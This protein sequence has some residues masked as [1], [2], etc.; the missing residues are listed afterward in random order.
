[1]GWFLRLSCVV[2]FVFGMYVLWQFVLQRP[3][4]FAPP[5]HHR[6]PGSVPAA[7]REI[8]S[9]PALPVDHVAQGRAI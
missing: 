9:V 7:D 1:M 8:R 6:T 3:I 5:P 2:I 4:R